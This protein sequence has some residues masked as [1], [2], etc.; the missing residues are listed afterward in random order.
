MNNKERMLNISANCEIMNKT[1]LKEEKLRDFNVPAFRSKLSLYVVKWSQFE[2]YLLPPY[3]ASGSDPE[4]LTVCFYFTGLEKALKRVL[5]TFPAE[6]F[7]VCIRP[8]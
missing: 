5:E 3:R 7:R 6:L 8:S 2:F 1:T 4:R